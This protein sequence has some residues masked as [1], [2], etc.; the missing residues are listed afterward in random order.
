MRG[1]RL[2]SAAAAVLLATVGAPPRVAAVPSRVVAAL[3]PAASPTPLASCRDLTAFNLLSLGDVELANTEVQ[4]PLGVAANARLAAFSVNHVPACAP[5]SIALAVGGTLNATTGMVSNGQVVVGG[6]GGGGLDGGKRV[7]LPQTVGRHCAPDG[8]RGSL[9]DFKGL[10]R[11]ARAVHGMLCAASPTA[12]KTV[13]TP[14]RRVEFRVYPNSARR[15][16][17]ICRVLAADLTAATSVE[18]IGRGASLR[19]V[20]ILVV[21]SRGM[22]GGAIGGIGSDSRSVSLAHKGFFGFLPSTT[23]MSFC[24]VPTLTIDNV[25]VPAAVLAPRTHLRS[26][27]GHIEGTVIVASARGGVEF[28]HAPLNC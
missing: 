7:V 1:T 15:E 5:R 24:G 10:A 27:Y 13:I 3:S 20:A 4:G 22:A 9:P 6:T 12:C 23:V 19:R 17:L 11:T 8:P 2:M 21:G 18:V 28:R 16:A 14:D 26:T 25:G